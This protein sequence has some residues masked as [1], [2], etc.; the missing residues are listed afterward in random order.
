MASKIALLLFFVL[1]ATGCSHQLRVK[2]HGAYTASMPYLQNN[3]KI[4]IID[5]GT[6]DDRLMDNIVLEMSLLGKI[7]VEYPYAPDDN[8]PV[9]YIME[10]GITKKPAGSWTN[11][12]ISFPG[13]IIWTPAWHGYNYSL[14]IVTDIK[15]ID[16]E[17]KK[18]KFTKTI[19]T[20][21][22][23][24]HSEFDR[25]WI[26]LGWFEYG[27]LPFLGGFYFMQYD[28][29]IT[30]EFISEFR[31]SYSRYIARRVGALVSNY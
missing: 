7:E 16:F 27:V 19:P 24:T 22:K 25:T 17:T 9:D 20:K 5:D 21:Y 1:L 12:L 8:N 3:L 18:T 28:E 26:E 11:F 23:C 2:N 13:Y 6:I 4:G 15:L 29:D 30:D 14:E 10:I 31:T